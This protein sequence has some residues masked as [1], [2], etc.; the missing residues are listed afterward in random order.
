M[1]LLD[2]TDKRPIYEQIVDKLSDLMIRGVL[3]ENMPLPSVRS[4]AAELSVNPNTVQRAY[5]ELERLNLTY[6]VKG[7]GCF[8]SAPAK[9]IVMRRNETLK[10]FI[11]CVNKARDLGLEPDE[12]KELIDGAYSDTKDKGGIAN[13]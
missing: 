9:L 8:V 7:K 3:S 10:D 12:L 6:S 13:D 1:I 4:L 5:N 2:Q 11:A